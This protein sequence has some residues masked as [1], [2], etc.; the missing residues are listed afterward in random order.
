MLECEVAILVPHMKTVVDFCLE[1]SIYYSL[2]HYNWV[3]Q[4][5][6]YTMN[7][8]ILYHKNL[9]SLDEIVL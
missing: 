2:R 9:P 4:S 7:R 1:V 6:K 8:K 5:I 3:G